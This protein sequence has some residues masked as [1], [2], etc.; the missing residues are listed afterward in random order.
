MALYLSPVYYRDCRRV[1]MCPGQAVCRS[2]INFG[3]SCSKACGSVP[4]LWQEDAFKSLCL[5]TTEV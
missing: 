1:G 2:G 3:L 5:G 4:F